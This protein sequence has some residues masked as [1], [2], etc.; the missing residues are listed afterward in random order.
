V[1]PELYASAH[2]IYGHAHRIYQLEPVSLLT[3]AGAG[4]S[5]TACCDLLMRDQTFQCLQ[6]WKDGGEGPTRLLSRINER[7]DKISPSLHAVGIKRQE[8]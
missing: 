2:G 7:M 6:K 1:L 3:Q 8:T 5:S 4:G